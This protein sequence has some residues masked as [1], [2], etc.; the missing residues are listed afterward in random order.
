MVELGRIE[1][2]IDRKKKLE[3]ESASRKVVHAENGKKLDALLKKYDPEVEMKEPYWSREDLEEA[4]KLRNALVSGPKF[5]AY[6]SENLMYADQEINTAI[7][8]GWQSLPLLKQIA[9]VDSKIEPLT[10]QMSKAVDGRDPKQVEGWVKL[11]GEREKLLELR[12][13]LVQ[14]CDEILG[15]HDPNRLNAEIAE[16]GPEKVRLELQEKLKEYGSKPRSRTPE[17]EEG[18]TISYR[19]PKLG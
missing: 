9:I 6:C 3:D 8:L 14:R 10:E 5:Q 11:H 13:Q 16:K 12:W 17:E 4:E 19:E 7:S 1:R 18:G 2:A 15:L